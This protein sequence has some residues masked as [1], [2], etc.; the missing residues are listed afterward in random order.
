ML[1]LLSKLVG[2]FH[3]RLFSVRVRGLYVRVWHLRPG[4][5]APGL[6]QRALR[7]HGP[8]AAQRQQQRVTRRR[9]RVVEGKTFAEVGNISLAVWIEG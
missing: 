1:F 8:S 6:V 5:G 3:L 2:G 4:P 9:V 7:T